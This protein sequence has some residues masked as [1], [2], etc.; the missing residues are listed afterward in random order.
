MRYEV[1]WSKLSS[2]RSQIELSAQAALALAFRRQNEGW[3]V[4]LVD[5]GTGKVLEG[6]AL[7]RAWLEQQEGAG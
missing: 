4:S 3:S 6:E 1:R 7:R 2:V 5:H